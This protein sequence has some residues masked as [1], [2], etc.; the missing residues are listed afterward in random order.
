MHNI[1][2]TAVTAMNNITSTSSTDWA[3]LYQ[4]LT[5][6]GNVPAAASQV[7]DQN[8][9]V[10]QAM[11][12]DLGVIA[13]T[14]LTSEF[15]PPLVTIYADVLNVPDTLNYVLQGSAL[16]IVARRIQT[17]TAP[18]INIDYRTSNVASLLVYTND[19]SGAIS[20]VAAVDDNGSV[21]PYPFTIS[22]PQP[23]GGIQILMQ[24]G[25]PTQVARTWAQGVATTPPQTFQDALMASFIFGSLLYDQQPDIALSIFTWVKDWSS[26][27]PALLDSFLRSTSMVTLL[28]SEINAQQNGAAFVPYLTGTIYTSLAQAFVAQAQDYETNYLALSTQETID[29]NAIKLAQTLLANQA[30]QSDYV[31]KLLA[32]AQSNYDNAVAAVNAAQSNFA[33]AQHN[34][35]TIQIEFQQIGIPEWE[36]EQILKAIISLATAVVT[37]GVGIA[38][39]LVGDEAAGAASAGAAV[40][41]AEA[42]EAAAQ[43]G[44]DIAK[45]AKQ[46]ADVMKQLKK[47][48]EGLKKV[49]ELSMAVVAAANDIQKAQSSTAKMQAIDTS[50]GGADLSG[51]YQ[52]QVYQLNADAAM[53]GP[54][55][56][57][58]EYAND[59]KLAIDAVA[60]YG[61]ALA[62]AQLAAINAG[63]AYAK[64]Q[65]QLALSQ[66]QQK[67][68]QQYVDG[69]TAGE[70]P[71]L[72]MMQ[73]FYQRYLDVKSSL[74]AALEGYQAS[75][76]YWA[77]AQSSVNPR[78]IDPVAKISTGL[79]D[80][81][82]ITLDQANA[83]ARFSPP[84]Q[85]MTQQQVVIDDPAVLAALKSNGTASWALQLANTSFSGMDRVRLSLVR[86]WL[87]STPVPTADYE[88]QIAITNS[89]NYLDR[90]QGTPYQFTAQPLVRGFKYRVS[91]ANE[92]SYDRILANGAYAYIEIDGA[93]DQEVSYAYF[94]P[95]PF[96]EW[97]IKLG[98]ST[99]GLDLSGVTRIVMEFAGSAIFRGQSVAAARG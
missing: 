56:Q 22:A 59:L 20:V 90:F 89:G 37:F 32:Q 62:A 30:L 3:A 78:I 95:T 72:A 91:A 50:T 55:S 76:F 67:N 69:L 14:L 64:V 65:L 66:A 73:L 8:H 31:T 5:T 60:I 4:S 85:S 70:Q 44:S 38:G 94:E 33:Q 25:V 87:E 40:E 93:V 96:S 19:V 61:Q 51:T 9:A 48:I 46:L 86:V 98:Q 23:G 21:K 49:Y 36:R 79:S 77:L 54:V 27:S 47:V 92:G 12:L 80:L 26:A 83:L 10:F 7:I 74:F 18:R 29:A 6:E 39:M 81:T 17:G 28:S 58:V 34:V 53:A 97:Q 35:Q 1:V 88:V 15:T 75:Y 42:V 41:G 82:A 57:G 16:V 84:P 11:Y 68:L 43:A 45:M 99:A 63:Q 2:R 13:T 24:N 52:W 71:V